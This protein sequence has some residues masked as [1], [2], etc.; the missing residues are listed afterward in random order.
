MTPAEREAHALR[1]DLCGFGAYPPSAEQWSLRCL[2]FARPIERRF[3]RAR[4]GFDRLTEKQM[5]FCDLRVRFQTEE[6]SE[7]LRRIARLIL[8]LDAELT[9]VYA[10]N[11]ERRRRA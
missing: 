3:D 2:V 8:K 4:P 9:A 10:R 6:R 1:M 7:K 5:L 11:Y